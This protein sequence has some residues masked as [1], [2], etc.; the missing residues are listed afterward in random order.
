MQHTPV[1]LEGAE[2]KANKGAR[3]QIVLGYYCSH[4]ALQY[5]ALAI[6]HQTVKS[7]KCNRTIAQVVAAVFVLRS[8]RGVWSSRPLLL[9]ETSASWGLDLADFIRLR[10]SPPSARWGRPNLRWIVLG[11]RLEE[12]SMTMK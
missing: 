5:V 10:T 9:N 7:G 6:T 8:E 3:S 11:C 4:W 2:I 1:K 12:T